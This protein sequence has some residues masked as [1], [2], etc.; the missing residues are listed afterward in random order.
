MENNNKNDNN[1]LKIEP[2]KADSITTNFKQNYNCFIYDE[3][4]SL[5]YFYLLNPSENYCYK[6][7]GK[8]FNESSNKFHSSKSQEKINSGENHIC[9]KAL[10]KP[11]E[12]AISGLNGAYYKINEQQ[13]VVFAR[14]EGSYILKFKN[15]EGNFMKYKVASG[16]LYYVIN[17]EKCI[18]MENNNV[19]PLYDGEDEIE[20]EAKEHEEYLRQREILLTQD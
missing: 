2:N 3:E 15:L 19:L 8:I 11:I 12:C 16:R 10:E 13:H 7:E 17:A 5:S 14:E 4:N 9:I 1:N 20:K 18:D 6:G